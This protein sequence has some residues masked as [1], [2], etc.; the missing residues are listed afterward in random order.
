MDERRIKQYEQLRKGYPQIFSDAQKIAKLIIKAH[1]K[2]MEPE[3]AGRYLQAL[4]KI[5]SRKKGYRPVPHMVIDIMLDAKLTRD[6]EREEVKQYYHKMLS[7]RDLKE[8]VSYIIR[9]N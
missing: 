1:K 2:H 7:I 8:Y 5:E 9:Y 4:E 6:E 3:E